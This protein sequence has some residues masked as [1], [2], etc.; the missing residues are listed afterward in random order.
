MLYFI[1]KQAL[2][3]KEATDMNN[4]FKILGSLGLGA[5]LM[6]TLDPQAGRRRRGAR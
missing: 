6:Y 1:Q 5:L 2:K 3:E 4:R